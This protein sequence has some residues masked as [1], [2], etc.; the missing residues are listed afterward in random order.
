MEHTFSRFERFFRLLSFSL[1]FERF[2]FR[3][4]LKLSGWLQRNAQ[5]RWR[6]IVALREGEST[7]VVSRNN[8]EAHGIR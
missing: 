7:A 4:T 6:L 3:A 5:H 8:D 1:L 2:A